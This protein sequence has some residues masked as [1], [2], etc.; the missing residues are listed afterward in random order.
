MARAAAQ[1]PATLTDDAG[2]HVVAGHTH[3]GITF[4]R[5]YLLPPPRSSTNWILIIVGLVCEVSCIDPR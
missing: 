5:K 3:Q 2:H 4:L 1:K